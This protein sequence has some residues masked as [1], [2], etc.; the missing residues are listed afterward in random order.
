M[1]LINNLIVILFN[2]LLV[3]V[4]FINNYC[5]WRQIL[6]PSMDAKYSVIMFDLDENQ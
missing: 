3:C 5:H 4:F 6:R 2:F 1:S